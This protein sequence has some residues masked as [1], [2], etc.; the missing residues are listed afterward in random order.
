[1]GIDSRS[2]SCFCLLALLSPRRA[3]MRDLDPSS[4][5]TVSSWLSEL[6]PFLLSVIFLGATG[7]DLVGAARVFF[8]RVWL[9][10]AQKRQTGVR[11]HCAAGDSWRRSIG[12]AWRRGRAGGVAH[13]MEVTLGRDCTENMSAFVNAGRSLRSPCDV[14]A[15]S[16]RVECDEIPETHLEST[17]TRRI[18]PVLRCVYLVLS[19]P[20]KRRVIVGPVCS[21]PSPLRTGRT[22]TKQDCRRPAKSRLQS[23]YHGMM[24]RRDYSTPANPLPP[25]AEPAVCTCCICCCT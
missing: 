21:S 6:F 11:C 14:Q 24:R 7:L 4:A 19:F 15:W 23:S 10:A 17:P 3:S 1:M 25:Q 8:S 13:T 18:S 16:G 12:G 9:R 20:C 2:S 22:G 5:L